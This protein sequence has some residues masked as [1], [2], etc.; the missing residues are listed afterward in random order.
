MEE[1]C[2]ICRS[3]SVTLVGIFDERERRQW[4]GEMEP[5]LADMVKACADVKIEPGDELPQNICMSCILDAQCSYRFKRRCEKS[6]EELYL[7]IQTQS[8]QELL[9]IK[10]EPML[11]TIEFEEES[12]IVEDMFDAETEVKLKLEEPIVE[13]KSPKIEVEEK[14]QKRLTS[15]ARKQLQ[16]TKKEAFKCDLCIKQFQRKRN[17]DEHMKIHTRSHIC[18]TCEQRFLFK[19]DLDLHMSV[20]K[21]KRPYQCPLCMKSFATSQNRTNHKCLLEEDHPFKCTHCPQTFA[22]NYYLKEHMLSHTEEESN[23]PGTGPHKCTHCEVGFH[24]KAALRVHTLSHTGERPHTCAFCASSFRS[25]QTLKIHVRIHTGEKPYK[26]PE[27]QHAFA[28]NKNLFKHRRRHTDD[29]PYKCPH[30]VMSFREKHHMKRHVLRKHRTSEN[31][32]E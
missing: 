15:G 3:H 4:E 16:E 1:L 29:R 32:L 8:N 23:K 30:C 14:R 28:D 27:C 22:H 21:S 2:R 17:L 12:F 26:C 31:D 18:Q 24:N 19:T 10:M 20:H 11:D 13:Q 25:K 6:H 7:A 9:S 5:I